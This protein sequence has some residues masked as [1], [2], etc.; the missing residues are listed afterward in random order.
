MADGR[1][2]AFADTLSSQ[3]IHFSTQGA[4]LTF[5]AHGVR[6]LD[7][8]ARYAV[9]AR[10]PALDA[11]PDLD[12]D[13][14]VRPERNRY[15]PPAELAAADS[16][17]SGYVVPALRAGANGQVCRGSEC[18]SVNETIAYHDHNW[19]TWR[20]VIWD[21][22]VA[23]AGPFDVLYGGVHGPAAD[24]A[25]RRG[26]RFLG[27][28]VD[29]VGVA[30]VLEPDELRYSG[31]RTV[32]HEGNRVSVPERLVWSAVNA[33]DSVTAE[34]DLRRVALSRLTLGGDAGVYF[35][36]MQGTMR[37]SGRIGGRPI[38]VS[39]PGFFETYLRP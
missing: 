20:G 38:D 39:G 16:F 32:E 11:G 19:G 30:A 1:R 27:Y 6:L 13:L 18:V 26:V 7:E 17:I 36:Q 28:V 15:F 21:W 35:A 37:L 22:G 34:I 10:L 33:S 24:E 4:D 9:R 23:H 3:E 14:E 12:I 8:P 2:L 29:S 31:G 5:G 25:R